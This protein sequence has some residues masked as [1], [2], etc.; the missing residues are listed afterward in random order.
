MNDIT[1]GSCNCGGVQWKVKGE[2]RPI[3]ACHCKKCQKQSGLYYAATAAQDD[4]LEIFGESLT[5]YQSSEDARRGFCGVCG[6]ALFWK[7]DGE[8]FTSILAGSID[9]KH[10]LKIS[11]HICVAEKSDYYE[12]LDGT[13]QS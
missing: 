7:K 9:S 13:P 4:T 2:M 8:S 10:N 1:N 11:K 12:I 5:W 3:V 6:S